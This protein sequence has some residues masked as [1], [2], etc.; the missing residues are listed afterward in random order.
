MVI[1]VEDFVLVIKSILSRRKLKNAM[2]GSRCCTSARTAKRMSYSMVSTWSSALLK[3]EGVVQLFVSFTA[4]CSSSANAGAKSSWAVLGSGDLSL[5]GESVP[6]GRG[7]FAGMVRSSSPSLASS[8]SGL[9]CRDLEG[10]IEGLNSKR[11]AVP[12]GS[13]RNH[14]P[15]PLL[16]PRA[17]LRNPG[18]DQGAPLLDLSSISESSGSD[19]KPECCEGRSKS[20]ERVWCSSKSSREA[21]REGWSSK[22]LSI[23][24]VSAAAI[25]AVISI[26]QL[27]AIVFRVAQEK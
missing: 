14:D 13:C 15:A 23:S 16:P 7:I 4:F 18:G 5:I 2:K 8:Y 20:G 1:N 6:G 12:Y 19:L 26:H 27:C 9:V 3:R 21:D 17:C 25:S 24:S 10:L 22:A 11:W